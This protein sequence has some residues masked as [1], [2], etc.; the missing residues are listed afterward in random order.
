MRATENSAKGSSG[1]SYVKAQFEELGWGA[2]SNPE[3]DLGTDLFLMARDARRFDL[4]ALVGAQVKNW[5]LEFDEPALNDGVEG[6]WFSETEDHF[7]Y[8]LE[9]RIPH[10]V[11]FYDRE[12]KVSYWVH[13]TPGATVSTGKRRKIF[14][15]K[16]Q[17]V[18]ADH[19]DTLRAV[20]TSNARGTTW[21]GS[22][23][24][25]GQEI[26][27][28]ARLRY[29]LLVPRLIAPHDNDNVGVLTAPQA[30]AL[31]TAVRLPGQSDL[32][33]GDQGLT[34]VEEGL[35]ANDPE[36]VLFGALRSWTVDGDPAPLREPLGDVPAALRAAHVVALAAALYEQGAVQ[37]AL[38][39]VEAV[40]KEHDD[41]NPVDFAW[42]TLHRARNLVQLGR[43]KEARDLAL[44]VAPIGQIADTD[45]TAR[46][47]SGVAAEM[48]FRL[49]GWNASNFASTIAAG[50]NVAS[51]WRAQVMT[52][53]LTQHLESAFK[54]WAGDSAAGWSADQTWSR[55]RSATLI[56]G[57]AGDTSSWRH[58]GTLLAEHMLMAQQEPTSIEAALG[59][60]YAAGSDRDIKQAVER[61]LEHGP[62]DPLTAFV[63]SLDLERATRDSLKS[64]LE[65]VAL[66]GLLLAPE[67]A[68]RTAAWL[69]SELED[70]S[71]RAERLALRFLYPE[72]LL[73]TLG[74]LYVACSAQAQ[75]D[76]RAF[77]ASLPAVED[78][79]VAHAVAGVIANIG[80]RHWTED[81]IGALRARPA[82][83][84][85]ELKNAVERVV[86]ARH[87]DAR[88][89]LLPR[90]ERGDVDAL[91][92]WGDVRDLPDAAAAGMTSATA[93]AVRSGL[94]A[95]REG[96]H[97]F[98]TQ[99]PFR[100]LVLM[101]VWHADCADW[102]TVVEACSDAR[103][104]HDLLD[105]LELM[106]LQAAQI[107]QAV[108]ND[109]RGPLARLSEL[110]PEP[111][112]LGAFMA[113]ESVSTSA[114]RLLAMLFPDEV[115]GRRLL[116]LLGGT[117]EQMATAA[118]IMAAREE[119]TSLPLLA[120]LANSVHPTVRSTVA[121]VLAEWVS[122]GVA[123]D[124]ARDLLVRL[125]NEPGVRLAT[126]VTRAIAG[127]PRSD[128][129][130]VTLEFLDD[131]PSAVVRHHVRTIRE[132]W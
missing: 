65:V 124:A 11:V 45:P 95:A 121:E 110:V 42:L 113:T 127:R 67:D 118:R 57:F 72:Q 35:A 71:A 2:V 48:L 85:F 100:R 56:S 90:I 24:R 41:Y 101:N 15:P 34:G 1:Q 53:G 30:I 61:M 59:L 93:A 39:L 8:W 33:D 103:Y 104:T 97:S 9:H 82:Q 132:S 119:A 78:Q 64:G 22:A 32:R 4:G 114:T 131:H 92:S 13:I 75:R 123:G 111:G 29:A 47:L 37:E 107:P 43:L 94:A 74:P 128:A 54:E 49:S 109:L 66:A 112:P 44:D 62:I 46:F 31:A 23:W 20:A 3:H 122:H 87:G 115:P 28:E 19:L 105:G 80:F 96:R 18:D 26:A 17:T 60:L 81:E 76:V 55:L 27:P 126:R 21:E 38:D 106:V 58:Q 25:P 86:A 91:A 125:L 89:G 79:S 102:D 117:S 130:E 10:I 52:F 16:T 129:A 5:A 73:K 51:W 63:G 98:G 12:G 50:D 14:V 108:R 120:A 36:S 99:S 77:I 7:T 84:N 69:I 116:E 40:L 83:D 70:S 88:S 68:D 6:W